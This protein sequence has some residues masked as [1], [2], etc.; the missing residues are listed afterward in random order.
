MTMFALQEGI[1]QTCESAVAAYGLKS[2]P[3]TDGGSVE[4]LEDVKDLAKGYKMG[5]NVAF[6]A[7]F[8]A[9]LDAEKRSAVVAEE[10]V[11]VVDAIDVEVE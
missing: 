7:R 4:V 3:D 6:T 10:E 11:A 1:I 8:V 9:T 5:S 2:V